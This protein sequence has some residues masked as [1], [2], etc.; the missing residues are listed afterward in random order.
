[1]RTVRS[2][3]LAVA[4]GLVAL[5]TIAHAQSDADKNIARAMG[6]EG[7]AALDKKDFKTAEDRCHRAVRLFD[8]AKAPVP[9]TPSSAAPRVSSRPAP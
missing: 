4:F 7:Q 8:E 9:P 6:Q 5:P 1:M 3:A 2:F